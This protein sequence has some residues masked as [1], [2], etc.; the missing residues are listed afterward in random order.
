MD[1]SPGGML[2]HYR[3]VEKIGEGGMGVVWSADDTILGRQVA[4]KVL[5]DHFAQDQERL[6]RFKQEARLLAALNHPNIAAIYGL[7]EAEDARYLVLELVPG[8]TLAERLARGPLPVDEALAAGKQI[9]EALEAAHE[10]G[11]I[12]RDLKPGNVK[13]TPDGIVK[14]L[15]FGLAKA[16]MPGATIGDL[17]HSPTLT[18]PATQAG[19]LLGTAAYMSPEQAR[20]KPVDSRTDIWAFGC[21]LYECLSGSRAF[22]GET[23]SDVMAGILKQDPDWTLL[24]RSAPLRVRDL[25][26][27]C[28]RKDARRRPQHMGDVRI[29][30]EEAGDDPT[31]GMENAV[32]E[33]PTAQ[34]RRTVLWAAA[35]IIV[36]VALT[37]SLVHQASST[38]GQVMRFAMPLPSMTPMTFA[39]LRPLDISPNGDRVVYVGRAESITQ[40]YLRE[41]GRMSVERIQGTVGG[42]N[43]FFSPDGEQIGF[44]VDGRLMTIPVSGGTPNK[45]GSRSAIGATWGPGDTIIFSPEI[46]AGLSRVSASGGPSTVL[47]TPDP[48]QGEFGHWLPEMLPDGKHVL[49]TI[50]TTGS[51]EETRIAVLDID[52][53]EYRTI[54]EGG[55]QARYA[56]SGHLIYMKSGTL[57]AIPFDLDRLAITGAPVATVEGVAMN[58]GNGSAHFSFSEGGSLIYLQSGENS[59]TIEWVDREGR[60]ETLVELGRACESLHLAPSGRRLAV[61]IVT[62]G[63]RDIWTYDLSRETLTRLTTSTTSETGTIWTPDEKRITFSLDTPPFDIYWMPADGSG[64]PEPLLQGKRDKHVGDWSPDGRVLAFRKETAENQTDLWTMELDGDRTPEPFLATPFSEVQPAFSS[65]GRWL[66]YA[67]NVSGRYEVYATPFPGP[68][69]RRQISTDGGTQPLWSPDGRELFYRNG[70]A[71]LAVSIELDPEL[72][73]G[74]PQVLFERAVGYSI[75]TNVRGYDVS[76]DGQRFLMLRKEGMVLGSV[77]SDRA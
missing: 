7:E 32:E 2:S 52:T 56:P 74:K 51:L 64:P 38:K 9:A 37:W 65:D 57:M 43:P 47:T 76:A 34:I 18:S 30:I 23:A 11:I 6:A 67:S 68:G 17:S 15:D 33:R 50:W 36:A 27:R 39:G 61:D 25:V 22:D 21:V 55:T 31:A 73:V 1:L 24:P 70:D 62:A 46:R 8:E 14:V 41:F 13:V 60:A 12:H 77:R 63:N 71:V 54:V 5:P 29:R 28:F 45:L 69:E 44:T 66:A 20:G 19:V 4:I 16:F 26:E 58:V 49:F 10:K 40:L 53:R 35:G 72:I 48:E 3:L 59:T 42:Q 75:H